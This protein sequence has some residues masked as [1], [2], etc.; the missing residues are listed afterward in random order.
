M[1]SKQTQK[2][3]KRTD[4]VNIRVTPSEKKRLRHLAKLYA[5]GNL[6]R[7]IVEWIDRHRSFV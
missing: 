2:S 1:R 5:K 7:M 3:E 6:S 4:I